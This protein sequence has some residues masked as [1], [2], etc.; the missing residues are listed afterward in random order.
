MASTSIKFGTHNVQG[1]RS[2][3]HKVLNLFREITLYELDIVF[4][5]ETH[6]STNTDTTTLES[7]FSNK[8]HIIHSL[9]DNNRTKGVSIL[10]K[11]S[12]PTTTPVKLFSDTGNTLIIKFSVN[13]QIMLAINVYVPVENNS[14]KKQYV[15]NLHNIVNSLI[16]SNELVL[17]AGDFNFVENTDIDIYTQT[18]LSA[19]AKNCY[20]YC[21]KQFM[22]LKNSLM[23]EDAYRFIDPEGTDV[24][25]YSV[26]STRGSRLDR[27]YL[28]DLHVASVLNVKHISPRTGDHFW[29]VVSLASGFFNQDRGQG[30]YK[31]NNNILLESDFQ[32]KINKKFTSY[33]TF[34]NNCASAKD[35][36]T[37]WDA[38]KLEIAQIAQSFSRSQAKKRRQLMTNIDTQIAQLQRQS[39]VLTGAQLKRCKLDLENAKAARKAYDQQYIAT[40]LSSTPY[41]D[42]IKHMQSVESAK[43]LA[44]KAS[45]NKYMYAM[46]TPNGMAT[47]NHSILDHMQQKYI[48]TFTSQK[49]IQEN[50]DAFLAECDLKRLT[51]TQAEICEEEITTQEIVDAINALK[52]NKTPGLDGLS[53]EF[54]KLYIDEFSILLKRVYDA[55][56]KSKQLTKSMYTGVIS[57]CYKGKGDRTVD[58][59]WRPLSML[60]VDYKILSKIL[61]K[62]LSKVMEELVHVD[63][64]CAIKNRNIHDSIRFLEDL[65]YQETDMNRGFIFLSVDQLAAFDRLEWPYLFRVIKA[66]G[67]GKNFLS[68]LQII[69]KTGCVQSVIQ[70]NGFLSDPI[71]LNRGVRQGCP[72]SALLYVLSQEPLV[73]RLR[74]NPQV[75]GV[76]VGGSQEF[77][78]KTLSYADDLN[79]EL[80]NVVSLDIVFQE[81]DLYGTVSGAKVSIEK[82]QI[83]LVGTAKDWHLPNK[84][85]DFVVNELKVFGYYFNGSGHTKSD[86]NLNILRT[87]IQHWSNKQPL[88]TVNYRQRINT[89]Q[90]Y[91]FS[92]FWYATQHIMPPATLM[93]ET[94]TIGIRFVW[95]PLTVVPISKKVIQQPVNKAGLNFPN[96]KLRIQSQRLFWLVKRQNHKNQ[97]KLAKWHH[98]FDYY[99]NICNSAPHKQALPFVRVP[100]FYMDLKLAMLEHNIIC[101]KGNIYVNGKIIENLHKVK[102]RDIYRLINQKDAKL[103]Q[104][105]QNFWLKYIKN[106]DEKTWPAIWKRVWS[107]WADAAVQNFSYLV[108]HHCV[109]TQERWFLFKYTDNPN[110]LYC[111]QSM[112]TSE[113]ETVFHMLMRC[114]KTYEFWD[115]KIAPIVRRLLGNDSLMLSD[116]TVIFGMQEKNP[117]IGSELANFVLQ[118]GKYAVWIARSTHKKRGVYPDI[119]TTF[120]KLLNKRV[121]ILRKLLP[122]T[123]FEAFGHNEVICSINLDGSVTYNL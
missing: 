90:T 20:K 83:L 23:L 36:L 74:S 121:K 35:I 12:L 71:L 96:F 39:R 50:I 87:T 107:T 112:Q 10:I 99:F 63:Q 78:D 70:V 77:Q 26:T 11:K 62:R 27:A 54:Y 92:N 6:Y 32:N 21:L 119:Y 65:I 5:Q 1:L 47:H 30:Y 66:M 122:L 25:H 44:K 82:T 79:L 37:Y 51:E 41:A 108:L 2:N 52:N 102:A 28:T 58:K 57:S 105:K 84:Y 56:F 7:L 67:F 97:G 85:H 109:R 64:T 16:N 55:A 76:R 100:E 93:K 45:I 4:L 88:P 80:G 94:E 38:L 3:L 61:T 69:Y 115:L 110:C 75:M 40:I 103:A 86:T 14:A 60:N 114:A 95:S 34:F 49:V 101:A 123:E 17:L 120:I 9:S 59:S 46:Q 43:K 106:I 72:L 98:L 91:Y 116:Q 104:D 68:W 118:Y 24:T 81:M 53:V 13:N 8:Y 15:K 29:V 31:M 33:K 113:I 19:T 111:Q 22:A 48:A 42:Q 89:L 18:P 73:A 117:I